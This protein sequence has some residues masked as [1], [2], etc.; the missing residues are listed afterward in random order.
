MLLPSF[1][2]IVVVDWIFFFCF[3]FFIFI[4]P[5]HE[6]KINL[7]LG[8][9][10]G[11]NRFGKM[12]EETKDVNARCGKNWKGNDWSVFS[13]LSVSFW[14]GSISAAISPFPRKWY[15]SRFQFS[16]LLLSDSHRDLP[17]KSDVNSN[18]LRSAAL[19][20]LIFFSSWL[21]VVSSRSVVIHLAPCR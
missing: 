5:F 3:F 6:E 1:V 21:F 20:L 13:F 12:E 11:A 15:K 8:N 2:S 4:L 7:P 18:C 16:D 9:W 17:P 10:S 19:H 14:L